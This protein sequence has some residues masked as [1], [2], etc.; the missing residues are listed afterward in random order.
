MTTRVRVTGLKFPA[1]PGA[2]LQPRKDAK[3]TLQNGSIVQNR[4]TLRPENAGSTPTT[5]ANKVCPSFNF[6]ESYLFH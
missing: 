1:K 5:H 4:S 3:T 2:S 6:T